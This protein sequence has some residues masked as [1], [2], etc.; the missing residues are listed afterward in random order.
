MNSPRGKVVADA[1]AGGDAPASRVTAGLERWATLIKGE[2]A[3][4]RAAFAPVLAEEIL[5]LPGDPRS[6]DR[7]AIVEPILRKGIEDARSLVDPV[8]IL[9]GTCLLLE[10]FEV[11][12][13]EGEGLID[14]SLEGLGGASVGHARTI[15]VVGAEF[16]HRASFSLPSEERAPLL[17]RAL[18]LLQPLLE[19]RFDPDIESQ[20]LL[21]AALVHNEVGEAREA[22]PL[23]ARAMTLAPQGSA[24]WA[25]A[26]IELGL[27]LNDLEQHLQAAEALSSVLPLV[28]GSA[29]DQP[30]AL[31]GVHRGFQLSE[32]ASALAESFAQLQLA[33]DAF[34][35]LGLAFVDDDGSATRCDLQAMCAQLADDELGLL[36]CV[37]NSTTMF[38]FD[39]EQALRVRVI[40]GASVQVWLQTLE[41]SGWLSAAFRPGNVD[42]IPAAVAQLNHALSDSL[43]GLR[44]ELGDRYRSLAVIP[45]RSVC[46]LPFWLMD[47]CAGVAVR[48]V[49]SPSLLMRGA[50]TLKGPTL[51]TIADPVGDL[52][53]A[54][55]ESDAV[56]QRVGRMFEVE[57]LSGEECTLP[58]VLARVPRAGLWH[59]AGHARSDL[60]EP[61]RSFLQLHARPSGEPGY[62]DAPTLGRLDLRGLGLIVLSACSS[63]VPEMRIDSVTRLAG[64]ATLLLRQG[65][66]AVVSTLWEVGDDASALLV[67]RLFAELLVDGGPADVPAALRRAT[68]HVRAMS[69][70]AVVARFEQ[71]AG[72]TAN[73]VVAAAAARSARRHR[74]SRDRAP[75]AAVSGW[76]AFF[77]SGARFLPIAAQPGE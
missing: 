11:P 45:H 7:A 16:L 12:L 70:E 9:S 4:A 13:K 6:R 54:L 14:E 19:G 76:G 3:A 27:S 8:A 37:N 30:D 41:A 74:A 28:Q 25:K 33:D 22:V 75:F 47:A 17:R 63:G 40:P 29:L 72:A 65:A 46:L 26:T 59:F 49:P 18:A 50:G 43:S 58:Q 21:L 44:G 69:R 56:T 24:T 32:V 61:E 31:P 64:L 53:S 52:P 62:L 77:A 55:L 34:E 66:G 2:D 67:D 36:F 39:R 15:L 10:F 1:A 57:Q 51:L 38:L 5:R 48:S 23:L 68:E 71:I 20:H 42:K 35:V 60:V 73:A